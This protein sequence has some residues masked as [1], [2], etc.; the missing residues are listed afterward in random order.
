ML[1]LFRKLQENIR[2]RVDQVFAR[3]FVGQFLMFVALVV[4]VTLVGMTAIFFGLFSEENVIVEAIPRDIDAGF[5]DSLWWSLNQVV[6]LRGFASAYGASLPVLVYSLFLSIAGLVVFSVLISLINN[7]MRN[8]VEALRKGD[9]QVLERNHVLVLGW[10]NKV[11]SVLRQLAQLQPGIKVVILAPREIGVMQEKLRVAGIQRQ[12]IKVILRSGN[13]SNHGELDRVAVN[14]AASVIVL[15]TDADDSETIK[16]IVLLTT[17]QDLYGATPVLTSEIVHGQNYELARIAAKNRLHVISSSRLISKVIV[18]TVRNPGLA[19]VYNE[20][21]SASGNSIFVQSMA[22]CTDLPFTDVAYGLSDAIPVGIMWIETRDEEVRHAAG[23][24]PEP[25]YEL[26][27]DEKLVLLTRGLPVSYS[28]PERIPESLI[29]QEG[30]SAPRVPARVLLIGWTDIL[31]DILQELDAHA[32]SGTEVTILSGNSEE[33]ARQ[34]VAAYQAS[35]NNLEN[36][37]LVFVEGDAVKQ[38]A[39]AG[40]DVSAFQSIVVL[41]DGSDEQGDADTRSLR[42]LLR[43]SRL[44]KHHDTH[45]HTVVELLDD[46]NRVL[47][48][49]LEV[50]DIIVSP[51]IV[52]AEL[53]QIARQ[54]LLAPIYQELL[55]AGGVE[56]S[57][58][59]AADYVQLDSDCSFSDLVYAS[60]Q[61][62]EIALGLR[63]ARRG[64]EVLLNPSRRITWRLGENDKVIVL[65]Q[66]VY[67]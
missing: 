28:R 32:R 65:A 35:V 18:Q 61:K 41:A 48:A 67:L 20:I 47:F 34:R 14:R 15:A 36:L 53:A 24:N 58:R 64:G 2:Y 31:Y 40:M 57:L 7:T 46:N 55:S 6:F 17:R 21:F 3:E 43:L 29:Y 5:W 52:S 22:N 12:R 30:G 37:T 45:A 60:Q 38:G 11:Y 44:R 66:Q 59:P 49:D 19:D 13:P 23:L 33:R 25:D 8:R 51:E 4:F 16:T 50:D 10:N 54:E 9:T 42:I 39:Y 27:E 62:M 26:A 1:K 56:I 63:L